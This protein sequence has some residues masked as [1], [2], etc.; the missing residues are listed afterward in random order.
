MGKACLT[1]LSQWVDNYLTAPKAVAHSSLYSLLNALL[2]GKMHVVAID[3]IVFGTAA[4]LAC[5]LI[6]VTDIQITRPFGQF[7]Q[8]LLMLREQ[9]SQQHR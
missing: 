8:M 6:K 3:D 5:S 9:H 1:L 2:E 7:I 4:A